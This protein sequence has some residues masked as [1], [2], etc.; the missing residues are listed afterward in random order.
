MRLRAAQG[1]VALDLTLAS[2]KAPVLQG[3]QG[4]SRKSAEPGNASY[5]YSMTRMPTSG[6]IRVG[7]QSF[8]VRGS[9]WMDR[10][11][12]TSALARDQ[13]GWDWLALQLSD[14][15]ELMFYRLRRRDGT[16]DPVSTGSLVSA[17]G[18]VRRLASSD[19]QI[20]VLEHW[21]SPRGV[22]Y[23][24]RWRLR[25]PSRQ[26]DQRLDLTITPY[27]SDQELDVGVRY[28]EGA[29]R[30]AGTA[31]SQ[32]VAGSGYV[33]LTGYGDTPASAP[34]H[35]ASGNDRGRRELPAGTVPY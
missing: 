24:S 22:R 12:S 11:W 1:N 31:G 32:P 20:E 21:R 5:Y 3:E 19:V 34:I 17:D 13:V 4:L 29:V 14:D 10:E 30:I 33:E 26:L 16:A 25:V 35:S 27:L 28:W 18:S 9:S 23:P 15:R 6:M 8:E 2:A 7:T